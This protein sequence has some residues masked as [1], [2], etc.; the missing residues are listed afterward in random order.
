MLWLW[1][2][3]GVVIVL[4]VVLGL[5]YN[6][7]VRLRNEVETGWANI[8]VQLQR[9]GDELSEQRGRAVGPALQL[10]VGLRG[11]PERVAGQFDEL[12][13][14]PVGR[15]ATDDQAG[16]H[17]DGKSAGVDAPVDGVKFT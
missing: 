5:G 7:L 16:V 4:A 1:I 13:Q 14:A 8:D 12:D 6:R 17:I 3:I 15:R 11:D 9:R 2:L 10:R